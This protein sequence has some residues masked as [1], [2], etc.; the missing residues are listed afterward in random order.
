MSLVAVVPFDGSTLTI[1]PV[2]PDDKHLL[3]AA[4]DRLSTRS[5]RQR[6]L[7]STN[8]L[9]RAQLAYLTEIDQLDHVAFGVFE[10]E[11]PVAVGRWIRFDNDRDAADVAL[12]VLDEYQQRGVGSRLLRVLALSARHREVG[13][14]H[15]DV[16]AENVGMLRLLDG[17][18]AVRTESGPI[19]HA[20][21]DARTVPDPDLDGVVLIRGL[22][23]SAGVAG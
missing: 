16:L 18:G 23:Q 5:R 17:F 13:W 8:G 2:R 21:L 19:I 12:T 7:T 4:F 11:L 3:Q 22:D 10:Q 15:F 14:L 20:V 9:T 1:R 6:F